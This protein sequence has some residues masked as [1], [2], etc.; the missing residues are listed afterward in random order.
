M[1]TDTGDAQATGLTEYQAVGAFEAMLAR[2]EGDSDEAEGAEA[3]QEPAEAEEAEEPEGEPEEDEPSDDETDDEPAPLYTVK[4]NGEELQVPLDELVKGYSREADYSRNKNALAEAQKAIE[5][6]KAALNPERELYRTLLPQLK[7]QLEADPYATIDL[8]HLRVNDPAE[9][10]AVKADQATRKEQLAAVE[11]EQQ[12]LTRAQQEEQANAFKAHLQQE[13]QRLVAAVPEWKDP[14]KAKA[15]F[16]EI[17]AAAK[18]RGFTDQDL[19]NISDHR[20]YL[21]LR[22]AA[23][24]QRLNASKP[25]AQAKVSAVKTARPGAGTQQP[26]KVSDYNRLRA[27]LRETGSE[28]V[29]AQLWE[30]FL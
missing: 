11:A 29:A 3:E 14:E 5:A 27:K 7:A 15:G 6:E 12:R 18:A 2:E 1:A 16:A 17:T 4:V 24:G 8:E 13:Q 28:K 25:K 22:D 20:L 9:Y 10:A 26:T 23:A 19:A 30:K 21:L